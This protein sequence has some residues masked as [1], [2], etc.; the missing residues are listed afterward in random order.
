MHFPDETLVIPRT[1]ISQFK[2]PYKIHQ[3][4]VPRDLKP[5]DILVKVAVASLCH[6]DGMVSD[7]IFGTKL[8][9]TASH[10]G[11]GTIAVVGSAVSDF[12]IGDR[13]MVGICRDPCGEC[14]ECKS[15]NYKQYC[16][17]FSSMVG[18]TSDGAFAE[19]LVADSR[20]CCVL[21]DKVSFET[22]AP[23]ACAGVTV[24]RGVLQSHLKAGEWLA[25]VGSGGGNCT[26]FLE[27]Q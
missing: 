20:T 16:Q 5:N 12:K 24:W 11:T 14:E 23:M 18:V 21:P 17:K 2:K 1:H 19:Y 8:P 3:V 26:P 22:A 6:T 4:P 25:I 10:E 9:C 15:E 13:V 27:T 7:G